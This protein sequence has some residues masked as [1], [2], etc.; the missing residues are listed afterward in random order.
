MAFTS[1]GEINSDQHHTKAYL[2]AGVLRRRARDIP[3]SV[4]RMLPDIF[5]LFNLE[6]DADSAIFSFGYS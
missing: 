3:L 5:T 4:T 1:G 2:A 6:L